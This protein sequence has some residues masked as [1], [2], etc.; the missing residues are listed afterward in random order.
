MITSIS[1]WS[2]RTWF[3]GGK[4][5]VLSFLDEVKQLGAGGVEIFPKYVDTD[6]PGGCLKRIAVKAKKLGLEISS[7]IAGN[8]FA[9]PLVRERAEQVERMKAT[10]VQAAAAGITRMNSFTG[11][12]VAGQDP[13]MEAAR[14]IDAYRE[15]MPLAEEHKVLLC[16]ENHSSVCTDADS[17]LNI[18]KAVGSANLRTNPVFTNFV[19]EFPRRSER[20][21]EAI[22]TETEKFAPLAINAHLKVGEFADD[23]EHRYYSVKR[24]LDIM[25]AAGYDGHVVL[26]YYGS[27][28]PVDACKKGVALLRKYA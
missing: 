7:L 22:Y 2:Y 1:A 26:E 17:I 3:E 6:D 21:L 12:H 11:Y 5:D 24:L 18:I 28:D 23:G 25:R 8:D 13:F 27:G 16:I 4:C 19:P 9:R 10:I 15:V 14:V 20:A